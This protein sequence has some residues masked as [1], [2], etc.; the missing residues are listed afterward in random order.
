MTKRGFSPDT[1][2]Q[3]IARFK[4]TKINYYIYCVQEYTFWRK[5]VCSNLC[6]FTGLKHRNESCGLIHKC[7]L[8]TR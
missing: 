1:V 3:T 4:V 2:F 5:T 6:F 7:I 8:C